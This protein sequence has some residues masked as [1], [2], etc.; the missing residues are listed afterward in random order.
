MIH[1]FKMFLFHPNA[2]CTNQMSGIRYKEINKMA[3]A[4][5]SISLSSIFYVLARY[6]RG[7]V[8]RLS[9]AFFGLT[10]ALQVGIYHNYQV[11]KLLISLDCWYVSAKH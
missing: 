8:F 3:L 10:Q 4:A 1:F 2:R 9:A 6:V 7:Y 5:F 11:W